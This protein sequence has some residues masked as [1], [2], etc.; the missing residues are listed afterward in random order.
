METHQIYTKEQAAELR[1][2]IITAQILPLIKAVFNKYYQLQ[3]AMLLVAQ[4]WDD[5]ANDAVHHETIFSVLPTPVLGVELVCHYDYHDNFDI[6]LLDGLPQPDYDPVNLEGLPTLRKIYD[7]LSTNDFV[8]TECE[9]YLWDEN[10][11]AIPAFAAYCKEGCH[12]DMDYLEAY[13]PYA[14]FRRKE[15]SRLKL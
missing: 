8:R 12:Q 1:Q 4:Y 14:I 5:E 6:S 9:E 11:N 15:K 13:T 2:K 10:K 7:S 3:S